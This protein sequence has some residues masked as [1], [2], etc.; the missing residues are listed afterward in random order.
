MLG[1]INQPTDAIFKGNVLLRKFTNA[2]TD[3]GAKVDVLMEGGKLKKIGF[4]AMTKKDLEELIVKWRKTQH[5]V[6]TSGF[7]KQKLVI[8]LN[9]YFDIVDDV[10]WPA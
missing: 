2:T 4:N 8:Y 6:A 10:N 5:V 7:N 1:F 3:L 9:S